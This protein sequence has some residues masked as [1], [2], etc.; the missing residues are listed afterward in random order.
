MESALA[1]YV[2]WA[3]ILTLLALALLVFV[4]QRGRSIIKNAE[5]QA[6]AITARAGRDAQSKISL[7]NQQASATKAAAEAEAARVTEDAERRRTLTEE[8]IARLSSADLELQARLRAVRE[9]LETL[10]DIAG[11]K[12]G[13]IEMISEDDLLSSQEYQEDRK[14]IKAALKKAAVDAVQNV[15]GS[16]ADVNIGKYIGVSARSDIAGSLLLITTEMLC[17]KVSA[18]TGHTSIEKLQDSVKATTA[19]LKLV[20]SRA[21]L[22]PEFVELLVKRLRI[23]INYKRARQVA[24]E[25][26]QELRA[27]EREETKARKEAEKAEADA[28]KVE[29]IK[30][31]AIAELEERMAAQN[32]DERAAH[33]VELEALR[34]ELAEAHEQAERA[35]SRAQDTR[36]GHVYVISNIGSFGSEVL[37]IG[38]TRRLNPLDRVKE[39]GDAS[40][41]FRF[42]VHALIESNDAPALETELHR[43]FDDRR[44]NKINR[45]KEYFRVSIDEIEKK[46]EDEGIDALV[47]PVASADEYYETLRLEKDYAIPAAPGL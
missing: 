13:S 18:T 47:V 17:A 22:A 29:E 39:L 1:N 25:R 43:L 14:A 20:D 36:Q 10:S 46:L 32:E 2:F 23:E 3:S 27:Q 40:V 35:R 33:S 42:D 5:I 8:R 19:L 12:A 15:R 6:K 26:Q 34:A 31:Q 16:N 21:T 4:W 7:A 11:E 9:R 44:I 38:M 37:K 41:P 24:K 28:L 45:R 30:R